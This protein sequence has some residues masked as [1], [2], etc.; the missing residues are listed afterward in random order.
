[1]KSCKF[2]V[3]MRMSMLIRTVSCLLK[4]ENSHGLIPEIWLGHTYC[5]LH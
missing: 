1:M 4:T 5:V 3:I 2:G